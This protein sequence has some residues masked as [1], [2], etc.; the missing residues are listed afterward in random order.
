MRI[1]C[2]KGCVVVKGA[3]PASM[4]VTIGKI[5]AQ[6]LHLDP[7]HISMF[8][9]TDQVFIWWDDRKPRPNFA[10]VWEEIKEQA[11]ND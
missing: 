11:D 5:T 6:W 8:G 9:P 2:L 4:L 1:F 3:I 10:I 7:K